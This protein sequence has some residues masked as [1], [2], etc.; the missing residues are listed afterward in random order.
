MPSTPL[1]ENPSLEHLKGQAK[2]VRDLIRSG[3]P[4]GLSMFDDFHP[5]LRAVELDE[6]QRQSFKTTDAQLIVAR[7]YGFASWQRLRDHI[8]VVSANSFTPNAETGLDGERSFVEN[9]CHDYAEDGPSPEDRIDEAHRMLAEDPSLATGSVEALATVGD[10][11]AL[12]ALLDEQP[13]LVNE[14][15]GPNGWPPLLYATYSRI[16]TDRTQWSLAETVRLLIER[17][18]D[19]NT[20]FLWRGLVPPFTALTGALGRGESHQQMPADRLTIARLLLEAGADPN[21]GQGLYNNGIGGQNHDD[22]SHLDLLVEFGLGTDTDGPWYRRLGDQLRHP[23]ELLYDEL[24]AACKR[25]RPAV[26]RYLISL[27]LDLDR[28]IGRSQQTPA[29]IASGEGHQAVLEVLAEA[30]VDTSPTPIEEA[31]AF[32]RTNNVDALDRLLTTES[33]LLNDLRSRHPGLIKNVSTGDRAMLER[34]LGLGFD[35]NDRSGTKSALHHAAEANDPARARFLIE[36]GADPNLADTHIGAT[37]WGWANHFH[38]DEAAAYLLPLTGVSEQPLP[39]FTIRCLDRVRTLASPT[40]IQTYLDEIH[41]L[42]QPVLATLRAANASLAI[43]L[44]HPTVSVALYLDAQGDPWHAQG[45]QFSDAPAF[46]DQQT[47]RYYQT[48]LPLES[49]RRIASEFIDSPVDQPVSAS[50][51]REGRSPEPLD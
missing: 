4:G 42:G 6:A 32:S 40:L 17:G 28:A 45:T 51:K 9:A 14:P 29:R 12:A 3:D 48:Y 7:L 16:D 24:E 10:Y 27:G 37:P 46:R 1:P 47:S 49:A 13:H 36:H 2:L 44:G 35:V 30:G 18:A 19:P 34:L 21:D 26:L 50:W 43:G 11:S 38:H 23:G 33:G 41:D 20:G 15:C 22:P 39:E 25:N 8:A 5:H 31:L